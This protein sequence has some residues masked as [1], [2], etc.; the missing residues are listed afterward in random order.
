M[1]R[2]EWDLQQIF[3][4]NEAFYKEIDKVKQLLTNIE[5]YKNTKLNSNLLLELLD[6][7]WKIREK[8]NN[9]LI[10]GS[11]MY[12]KNIK[13]D[14]CI[15]LKSTAETFNNNVN[16]M[17]KF[18]DRKI[19]DLGYVKILNFITE[20]PKLEIYKLSLHNL[21]RLEEHVQSDEINQKLKINND[22]INENLKKYNNLLRDIKFG[23]INVND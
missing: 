15:E 17:L 19:L 11:L 4:S 18:V 6:E 2:F 22:Q 3:T 7:K 14:E 9:I 13:D 12:Y 10:Y 16:T 20:N 23:S 5:K 1:A 21:F 8:S